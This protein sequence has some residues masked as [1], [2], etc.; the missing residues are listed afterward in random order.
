MTDTGIAVFV[1]VLGP[2]ATLVGVMVARLLDRKE[3]DHDWARAQRSKSY[4]DYL[5]GVAKVTAPAG[6]I[7]RAERDDEPT[8][9]WQLDIQTLEVLEAQ[10]SAV[11]VFGSPAVIEC[12]YEFEEWFMLV[13]RYEPHSAPLE[14]RLALQA[15][16]DAEKVLIQEMRRELGVGPVPDWPTRIDPPS[17]NSGDPIA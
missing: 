9:D 3:G 12:V 10:S 6:L 11:L 8:P 13:A 2:V 4:I 17:F 16:L 15:L 7:H 14:F 1:G 5:S